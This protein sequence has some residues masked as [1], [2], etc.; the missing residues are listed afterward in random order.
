MTVITIRNETIPLCNGRVFIEI[1]GKSM[2]A[3]FVFFFG[4]ALN[5]NSIYFIMYLF[6]NGCSILY[7]MKRTKIIIVSF[8]L[9]VLQ[10]FVLLLV[11]S[12]CLVA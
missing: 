4:L 7:K 12:S 3:K 1:I 11:L 5:I 6:M 9:Y 8:F 10:L 2:K